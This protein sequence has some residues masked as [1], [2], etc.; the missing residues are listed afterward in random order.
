MF[1]III[2]MLYIRLS[3]LIYLITE[4]FILWLTHPHFFH[5]QLLATTIIFCFYEFKFFSSLLLL[6][7]F[8]IRTLGSINHSKEYRHMKWELFK[9]KNYAYFW[10][11]ERQSVNEKG[12]REKET[13]NLKQAPGF[14]LPAQSPNWGSNSQ[15]RSWDLMRSWPESRSDI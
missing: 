1:L 14:K 6:L 3:E 10:E 2:T 11:R 5:I 7:S 4:S 12:P 15:M 8:P 13:Q 9:E